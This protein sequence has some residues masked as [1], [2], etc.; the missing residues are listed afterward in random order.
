MRACVQITRIT[1]CE[2]FWG[3]RRTRV[4]CV[5]CVVEVILGS[6]AHGSVQQSCRSL[7]VVHVASTTSM[8]ETRP[9]WRTEGRT[10]WCGKEVPQTKHWTQPEQASACL[11]RHGHIITVC[12]AHW[13]EHQP[14]CTWYVCIAAI[15]SC[16]VWGWGGFTGHPVRLVDNLVTEPSLSQ[17]HHPHDAAQSCHAQRTCPASSQVASS[18]P[19]MSHCTRGHSAWGVCLCGGVVGLMWSG[20][21]GHSHCRVNSGQGALTH[22]RLFSGF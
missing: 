8:S 14:C 13:S 21:C 1:G 10:R 12:P 16:L 9:P 19:C 20:L 6:G 17:S 18:T 22:V 5:L 7:R 4:C 11:V 3:Q 2:S 15:G